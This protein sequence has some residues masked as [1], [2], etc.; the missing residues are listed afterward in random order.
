MLNLNERA[1]NFKLR[2]KNGDIHELNKINSEY[3]IIY[4][5]PKDD[6]S[7]CTIESK[8]FSENLDKFEELNAKVIG[9]SGGDEESKKKFIEKHN[10]KILLLS[11]PYF[12]VCKKYEVYGW[13]NFAGN[14]FLGINRTTYLLE[15]KRVIKVFE[16]VKAEGHSEEVLEF[17]QSFHSNK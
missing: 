4:F 9:I 7:G 15:N 13:K 2:D 3:F 6:T 14:K 5:Y 8:E 10:L 11:D 12:E 16:N 17:I 1:P